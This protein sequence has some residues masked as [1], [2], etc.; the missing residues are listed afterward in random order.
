MEAGG[1]YGARSFLI[2]ITDGNRT[3]H[4]RDYFKSGETVFD[5]PFFNNHGDNS[6]VVAWTENPRRRLFQLRSSAISLLDS[7]RSFL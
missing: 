7:Q 1:C 2:T 6:T 4:V 5:L 3:Q